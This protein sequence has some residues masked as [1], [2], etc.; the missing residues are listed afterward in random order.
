MSNLQKVAGRCPVMGQAMAVQL[1]T[2]R[3]SMGGAASMGATRAFSGKTGKASLHTSR[4]HEARAV[5]GFLGHEKGAES[6]FGER[7]V[8]EY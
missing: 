6:T 4:A 2:G 8:T 5:E 3:M 1:K 7:A